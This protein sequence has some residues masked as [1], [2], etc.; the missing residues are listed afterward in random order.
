M[1]RIAMECIQHGEKTFLKFRKLT[2]SGVFHFSS[3]RKGWGGNGQ[4]RFTGDQPETY[5]SFRQELAN[6]FQLEAKQ[7]VI[8]RQVHGKRVVV[9][10]ELTVPG[11]LE[12]TDALITNQPQC[13]ICVQTADCVP[14]LLYDPVRR[15]VGAVHAGWRGTVQKIVSKTV[16]EM[17]RHFNTQPEDLIAGIGPSIHLHAYEVGDEV[18]RAVREKLPNYRELLKPATTPGKAYLDLWEANKSQLVMAGVL[19]E[20]I[21]IM[22]FC[23]FS[24]QALFYSARRDGIDTG[25]MISGIMLAK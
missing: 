16:H 22:G 2:D 7:L 14:I 17:Q 8:P 5:Q 10:N 15:V 11:D 23:S 18:I 24:H 13:C 3:T 1:K 25:R 9:V 4:S 19:E 12:E 6:A 20:Q 21:E